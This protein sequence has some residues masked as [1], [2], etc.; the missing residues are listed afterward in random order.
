MKTLLLS[1]ALVLATVSGAFAWDSNSTVSEIQVEIDG[2]YDVRDARPSGKPQWN[3]PEW[4]AYAAIRRE[5]QDS[6]GL[7]TGGGS[8]RFIRHA[9][10]RIATLEAEAAEAAQVAADAAE[11]AAMTAGLFTMGLTCDTVGA[12]AV[13]ALEDFSTS[14][15]SMQYILD[16]QD[17]CS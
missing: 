17:S 9:E 10:D 2:H 6:V 12:A 7:S 4:Q 5:F 16:L 15:E 13:T 14:M 1:T 11:A 3:T 8:M